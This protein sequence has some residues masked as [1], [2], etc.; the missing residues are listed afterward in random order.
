MP[1]YLHGYVKVHLWILATSFS[2][3]P[4]HCVPLVLAPNYTH[5]SAKK[6]QYTIPSTNKPYLKVTTTVRSSKVT[7]WITTT[8]QRLLDLERGQWWLLVP[9]S[10]IQQWAMLATSH[11][12]QGWK[13]QCHNSMELALKWCMEG[14]KRRR[15]ERMGVAKIL[16][17]DGCE[18]K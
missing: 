15:S 17:N 10:W 5:I 6:L 2:Y 16:S 13:H 7:W 8:M 11:H 1:N 18:L 4:H 12:I 3:L 9:R 14:T